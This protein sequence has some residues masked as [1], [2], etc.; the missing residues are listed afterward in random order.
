MLSPPTQS[1]KH[2]EQIGVKLPG[3]GHY[4]V[5]VRVGALDSDED[6]LQRISTTVGTVFN[7]TGTKYRVISSVPFKIE[8]LESVEETEDSDEEESRPRSVKPE[9]APASERREI[10]VKPPALPAASSMVGGPQVGERWKPRDPRRKSSFV[11]VS[12]EGDHAVTD[13]GRKIQ[14]ARFKRYDKL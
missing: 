13:D 14:L 3:Q 1:H 8:Q 11:V 2:E 9:A 12:V 6:V 5:T 7:V 10:S 4:M